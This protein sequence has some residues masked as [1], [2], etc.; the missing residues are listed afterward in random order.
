[1]KRLLKSTLFVMLMILSGVVAWG[2]SAAENPYGTYIGSDA[3][4]FR[5]DDGSIAIWTPDE[6]DHWYTAIAQTRDELDALPDDLETSLLV[7]S[8]GSI[9][10]YKL[11]SGEY[12]VNN[13]PDAEG[14]VHVIVFNA[15]FH[16]IDHYTY[17][18]YPAEATTN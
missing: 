13:G 5:A 15:D 6:D 2:V 12:Q 8:Y 18:V 7:D 3:I 16:E 1:M 17:S 10:V 4:L 14:K 11:V 9:S